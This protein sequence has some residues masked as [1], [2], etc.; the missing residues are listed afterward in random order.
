MATHLAKS[1]G[2]TTGSLVLAM[3]PVFQVNL[4]LANEV[5]DG[6]TV[7]VHDGG[8]DGVVKKK[9]GRELKHLPKSGFR[10]LGK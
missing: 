2:Q 9:E 1:F 4:G 10:L 7:P 8:G 5:I 6:E 3:E